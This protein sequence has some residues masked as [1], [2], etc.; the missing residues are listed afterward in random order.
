MRRS[1]VQVAKGAAVGA[2]VTAG[3]LLL[4]LL[5]LTQTDWGREKVRGFALSE[6][7]Q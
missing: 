6:Q 4:I 5:V 7:S 1:A 3:L 2:A